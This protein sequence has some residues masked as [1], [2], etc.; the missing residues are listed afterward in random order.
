MVIASQALTALIP[1]LLLAATLAPA[2]RRDIV[3]Q[4]FV[5]RF[6]LSGNAA[7]AVT[8]VFARPAGGSSIGVLSVVILVFSAVSLARR[9]QRLYQDAWRLAPVAGVRGSLMTFVGLAALLLQIALLYLARSALRA[10]PMDWLL[11]VTVSILTGVLLW[12]CVPW[13][14]LDGRVHWRRLVPSGVLASVCGAAYSVAS[15]IYMP[16]MMETNSE[17]YGLFGVTLA[18][19]GW[20][21]AVALILVIATVI[22]AEFDRSQGWLARRVRTLLGTEEDLGR[23]VSPTKDDAA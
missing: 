23:T 7:E 2:D 8:E 1:L 22:G 17:R 18:L 14:L 21:L 12:I 5:R 4:G 20:L 19:V 11:S 15:T 3:A 16:R 9:L 6:E 13:L 10:L